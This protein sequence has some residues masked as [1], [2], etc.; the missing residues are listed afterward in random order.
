[1][2]EVCQPKSGKS[3][4]YYKYNLFWISKNQEIHQGIDFPIYNPMKTMNYFL[5]T[6]F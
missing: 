1:M 2:G 4:G 6:K 3:K 5:K